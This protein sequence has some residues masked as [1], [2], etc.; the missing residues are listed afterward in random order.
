V[1][2]QQDAFYVPF[3][4]FASVSRPGPDIQIYE[5]IK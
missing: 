3:A 4:N 1:Y 5:R 2:D